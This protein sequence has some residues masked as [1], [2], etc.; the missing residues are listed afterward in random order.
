M[1]PKIIINAKAGRPIEKLL[2]H[3][4]KYEPSDNVDRLNMLYVQRLLTEMH[5][6]RK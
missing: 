1:T 6:R 3:L 4:R 2:T 5:R